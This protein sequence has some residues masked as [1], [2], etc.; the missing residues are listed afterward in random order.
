MLIVCTILNTL[1]AEDDGFDGQMTRH[2]FFFIFIAASFFYYF[3]PGKSPLFLLASALESVLI[4]I[5]R[6]GYLFGALSYFSWICWIK[7]S[8]PARLLIFQGPL[9]ARLTPKS[10]PPLD[11]TTSSSISCL[12][13]PP[14]SEWAS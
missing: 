10:L 12:G 13:P 2:R 6:P 3:L 8:E 14:A 7:P 4:M 11:Q 5:S 9:L 1:H